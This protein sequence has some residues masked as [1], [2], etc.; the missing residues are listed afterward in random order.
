MD[1]MVRTGTF[2]T[3]DGPAAHPGQQLLCCSM[4]NLQ[5]TLEG[6]SGLAKGAQANDS[7]FRTLAGRSDLRGCKSNRANLVRV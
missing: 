5:L 7:F 1:F 4:A 6:W 3:A 2:V